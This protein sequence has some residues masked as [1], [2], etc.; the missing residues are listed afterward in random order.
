M[1]LDEDDLGNSGRALQAGEVGCGRT[2]D[3]AAKIG[4]GG[5]DGTI[6]AHGDAMKSHGCRHLANY[7]TCARKRINGIIEAEFGRIDPEDFQ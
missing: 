5:A 7:V 2:R 1:A 4:I 6:G 3:S